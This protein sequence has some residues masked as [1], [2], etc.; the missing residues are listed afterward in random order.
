[1]KAASNT[2]AKAPVVSCCDK[3]TAALPELDA[4]ALALA[5]VADWD[6]VAEALEEEAAEEVAAAEEA[7]AADVAAMASAV[8]LR[9][10]HC[11]FWAQVAWP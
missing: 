11:S 8:A 10:P 2:T 4:E 9:V 1:L 7:A 3:P 5:A 6:L